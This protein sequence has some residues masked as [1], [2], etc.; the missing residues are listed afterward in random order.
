MFWGVPSQDG[1]LSNL[2]SIIRRLNVEVFNVGDEFLMHAFQA[3]L[4]TAI[5][6]Q[7]KLENPSAQYDHPCSLAWLR[8]EAEKLVNEVLAPTESIDPINCMHKAFL[9][10]GY[11]YV[12]LR[13][14][15]RWD[16][17][18]IIRHWRWWLPRFLATGYSNYASEAV[19]LIANMTT[20]Y[21]KHI[22]YIATLNRNVNTKGK[23][24]HGKPV[25]QMIERYNL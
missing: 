4:T 13:E 15:I 17:P 2:R 14:A 19:N 3:H 18:H 16:G 24:G 23:P 11:S 12:D 1:S 20:D 5:M 21:P 7:L 6:E 8:S 25:D 10:V 22:A 9:H